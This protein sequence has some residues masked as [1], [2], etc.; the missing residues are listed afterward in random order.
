[1][2]NSTTNIIFNQKSEAI[3]LM[4]KL[5][6][7]AADE[8]TC[9]LPDAINKGVIPVI[10]APN[11]Y[12]LTLA[13][14]AS[15][16]GWLQI[17]LLLMQV[18]AK[19]TSLE[20]DPKYIHS[21]VTSV[22]ENSKKSAHQFAL[23]RGHLL[24]A[25]VLNAFETSNTNTQNAIL[26][27][28][29]ENDIPQ[30]DWKFLEKPQQSPNQTAASV[31]AKTPLLMI[32]VKDEKTKISSETLS[33]FIEFAAFQNSE[34]LV[35]RLLSLGKLKD[36]SPFLSAGFWSAVKGNQKIE[37]LV[38]ADEDSQVLKLR[39]LDSAHKAELF[40]SHH[41][42]AS[43]EVKKKLKDSEIEIIIDRSK[44][45]PF[46]KRIYQ[47][48]TLGE[49]KIISQYE[50]AD[51]D[52]YL[53]LAEA[54]K[55]NH[56]IAF[57]QL[58]KLTSPEKILKIALEFQNQN[59]VKFWLIVTCSN[60]Y[61]YAYNLRKEKDLLKTL[62][63][64][65][66]ST[67]GILH[68]IIS[69]NIKI[70]PSPFQEEERELFNALLKI[71]DMVHD[72]YLHCLND[73]NPH[74]DFA[75][76]LKKPLDLIPESFE[77]RIKKAPLQLSTKSLIQD[78]MERMG[79]ELKL[80]D[81]K[82]SLKTPPPKNT[83]FQYW[84]S[85]LHRLIYN[86][87]TPREAAR[88]HAL[89]RD[90]RNHLKFKDTISIN[91]QNKLQRQLTGINTFEEKLQ[92]EKEQ[93]NSCSDRVGCCSCCFDSCCD[94]NCS[95]CCTRKP[96]T[97]WAY[98]CR[99]TLTAVI[100]GGLVPALYYGLPF[101]QFVGQRID[102]CNQFETTF[103]N[104]P[105][106]NISCFAAQVWSPCFSQSG[107]HGWPDPETDSILPECVDLCT[108]LAVTNILGINLG[109]E[110]VT[111]A[112]VML[113]SL[114]ILCCI[115]NMVRGPERF[116]EIPMDHYSDDTLET[117]RNVL[118]EFKDT[119]DSKANLSVLTSTSLVKDILG[120]F[121]EAKTSIQTDLKLVSTSKA[122]VSQPSI[123]ANNVFSAAAQTP[124]NSIPLTDFK[125]PNDYQK[126]DV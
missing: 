84:P 125:D 85:E 54:H 38:C 72:T 31:D 92:K 12:G 53:C 19:I 68:N 55:N 50:P 62:I 70:N 44:L 116:D 111:P 71:D 106:T 28:L 17:I 89:S 16:Q 30:S 47:A 61:Q 11:K 124:D 49:S 80:V 10:D 66:T 94:K 101:I 3:A 100:V 37:T 120:K 107:C 51:I 114:L 83:L 63:D 122:L 26:F 88:S 4:A 40:S 15:R 79:I 57:S 123:S 23:E 82:T 65:C 25:D 24:V 96:E 76:L 39:Q 87:L 59:F 42:K 7:Q 34:N 103:A 52:F 117:F 81:N 108:Q 29:I 21:E 18:G 104:E 93:K 60:I 115:R 14:V 20:L 9:S 99:P 2:T 69:R 33:R 73:M 126:L 110:S 112:T 8:V 43:T 75:T 86:S 98:Y 105:P 97:D 113:I 46:R 5:H 56:F 119:K 118:S 32:D 74:E 67:Q 64:T 91:L 121:S 109:F 22:L 78:R 36:D 77:E 27:Y 48:A 6:Q 13:Q 35:K 95:A 1:M 90:I 58:K 45:S 102:L 41:A